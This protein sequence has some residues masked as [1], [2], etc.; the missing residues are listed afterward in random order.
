MPHLSTSVRSVG[1]DTVTCSA[2]L[3]D[4]GNP[5]LDMAYQLMLDEVAHKSKLSRFQRAVFRGYQSKHVG[6]GVSRGRCLVELRGNAAYNHALHAIGLAERV[7]RLDVQVSVFQH[8]YDHDMALNIYLG[9]RTKAAQRGRP[10][11]F[12]MQGESDGGTTLYVGSGASRY[13]AR[14]Y[15]R[16]YK[17]HDKADKDV[18]RYEVQTRRERAMQMA[19]IL[20]ESEN[21]LHTVQGA[22]HRHF[23]RRGVV[24][25]FDPSAAVD[26][27]PLPEPETDAERSLRWL[28]SSVAPALDRHRAWGSYQEAIQA[29]G[30][31]QRDEQK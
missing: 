7:S 16:F 22:V 9:A 11:T 3:D 29:L 18:W 17:S 2:A 6:W 15:E 14:L 30:I 27:P 20:R 21:T 25:I 4:N 8:P 24:P 19:D 13:Q 10:S 1:V 26:I 23:E 5:L 31:F 28:G 12:R